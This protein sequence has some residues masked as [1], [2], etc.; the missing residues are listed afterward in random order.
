[1]NTLEAISVTS[2]FG[3]SEDCAKFVIDDTTDSF[4][5]AE[6]ATVGQE[7]TFSAWVKSEAA[8]KLTAC[9]KTFTTSAGWA[10]HSATFTA[11]SAD[12]ALNFGTAGTYYVYH[13]QLELGNKVTDWTPAPEDVDDAIIDM[14]DSLHETVTEQ[15]TA[16]VSTCENI[17]LSALERYVETSDYDE[18]KQT[19]ETQLSVM[20]DEIALNFTQS[21]EQISTVN[22][23]LQTMLETLQK[24]FEFGVDGL[25]IRA[26]EN[27]MNLSLDND[28]I[29]FKKNGVQFGWWDG[30]DFH[31]GNIVVEVN[32]RAQFG[33][34]AFVP[35]S[36]GSL[37]FLKVGG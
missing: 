13:P 7:Y 10:K 25:T 32:E 29:L 14:G 23:E 35:R 21:T 26:G 31:T 2:P 9:G 24:H 27:S 36:D 5:L 16:I 37:M 34:F 3:K 11:S 19:V 33:S 4:L 17:I 18:F 20:A 1:M 30:V 6:I 28:M 12:V 15:N 22:G 8:G